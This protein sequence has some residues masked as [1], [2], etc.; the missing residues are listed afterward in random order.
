MTVLRGFV[1]R[2]LTL[3]GFAVAVLSGLTRRAAWL[4]EACGTFS[5]SSGYR[6]WRRLQ[7]A[8]SA[9]RARLCREAPAPAC[10]SREPL[11]QLLA[12]FAIVLGA[13]DDADFFGAFQARIQRGLFDNTLG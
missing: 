1:V 3:L 12:H 2:T 5:I 8:Q 13:G 6:L 7:E 10:A 9:L 4:R 11:S